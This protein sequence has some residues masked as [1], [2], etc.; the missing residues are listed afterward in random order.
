MRALRH[1]QR[2][3]TSC[4]TGV[5]L[6]EFAISLPLLL[7]LV[8]GLI[9]MT[10]FTLVNQKLDKLASSM[11]DFATQG[12][13]IS[14]AN[15]N[16]FG[17]AV[18][19]IMKP[20]SFNGTVVFSSVANFTTPTAPCLITNV[21]CISWQRA[22]LGSDASRIGGTGG[23]ATIPGGYTVLS[24][25]NIIVAEIIH[26]YT[27]LLSI[28]GNFISAFTAQTLYKTAISKPRQGTLTT[29]LP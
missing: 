29:L 4:N 12:Q 25:Q 2:F 10:Y 11:A 22:I 18:P 19:Q 27:P 26:S 3:L 15:I 13:T 17:L 24:A 5:A 1:F 7:I 16:A 9:E 28:S 23:I 6:I 21:S 8:I 14:V 20:F